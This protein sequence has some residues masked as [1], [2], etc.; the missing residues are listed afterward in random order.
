MI[1]QPTKFLDWLVPDEP[2][3]LVQVTDSRNIRMLGYAP[4]VQ[5]KASVA[6]II[7]VFKRQ[8]L[9]AEYCDYIFL[10]PPDTVNSACYLRPTISRTKT[11]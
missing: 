3:G 10:Y 8:C 11:T 6:H 1:R 5:K 2:I 9:L 4:K 7:I